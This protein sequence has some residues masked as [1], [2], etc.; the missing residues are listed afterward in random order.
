MLKLIYYVPDKTWR[1]PRKPSLQQVQVG[2]VNIPTVP[3]KCW[4]LDNLSR[5][6]AQILILGKSAS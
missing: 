3:G 6:K 5:S 1:K 4:E 2:L